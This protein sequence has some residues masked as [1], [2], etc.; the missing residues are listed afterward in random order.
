M[1]TKSKKVKKA[2]KV[3]KKVIKKNVKAMEKIKKAVKVAPAST[4][5][6]NAPTPE[7]PSEQHEESVDAAVEQAEATVAKVPATES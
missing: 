2:K 5:T 3:T 1:V 7:L 6:G 4:E